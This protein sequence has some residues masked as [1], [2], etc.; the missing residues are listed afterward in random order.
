MCTER[1]CALSGNSAR[2]SCESLGTAAMTLGTRNSWDN[3]R[4][5]GTKPGWSLTG[6]HPAA[7]EHCGYHDARFVQFEQNPGPG[8]AA[9]RGFFCRR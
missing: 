5:R 3:S 9:S 7:K 6:D 4:L 1:W 2:V 8:A